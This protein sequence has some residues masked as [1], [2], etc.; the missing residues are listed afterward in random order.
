[1]TPNDPNAPVYAT[2]VAV[3]E[4]HAGAVMAEVIPD[5]YSAAGAKI[6]AADQHGGRGAAEEPAPIFGPPSCSEEDA[7]AGL[8]NRGMPRG[9]AEVLDRGQ[10]WVDAGL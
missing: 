10:Q 9:L 2:A 1:M 5:L 3:D 4:P 7:I 6:A 8:I